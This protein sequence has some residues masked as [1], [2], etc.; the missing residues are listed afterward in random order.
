MTRQAILSIDAGTTGTRAA[1]VLADSSIHAMEYRRLGVDARGG[2]VVEQDASRI[3]DSTLD[4]CRAVIAHAADDGVQLVALALAAQR[5]TGILWDTVTGHPLA[6]AVVWQDS[7]NASL[8]GQLGSTWDP[9]LIERVGRRSGVHSVYL[10]A[11]QKLRDAPDVRR[12]HAERRLAFG[13]V[14]SWLQW[15]LVGG[16]SGE[17][18]VVSATHATAAGAYRLEDHVYELEWIEATGLPA[19]LLPEIRED[20]DDFGCTDPGLLGVALPIRAAVGDQ[21]AGVIGLGCRSRAVAACIHGTGS[22]ADLMLGDELPVNPGRYQGTQMVV[23][24]RSHGRS[25]FAAETYTPTTGAALDWACD[26]AGLFESPK[27]VSQLASTVR[28]SRGA[29]FVPALTGV[30]TP[31]MEPAARA[32]FTGLSLSTTRAEIALAVL[33]GI[34]HSVTASARANESAAGLRASEIIV[35]GGLAASDPL[36]QLQADL[37]GIPV[38][39]LRDTQSAS[40]RGAAFLAGADG[41]LWSSMDAAVATLSTDRVCEPSISADE[42]EARNDQ[43]STRVHQEL[44]HAGRDAG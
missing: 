18:A 43:W 25:T 37:H 5:A 40:I 29:A 30:R 22:F 38:R 6:P 28:S 21:P 27:A 16:R 13:T 26:T 10:W 1:Y 19:E 8:L 2:G 39:R 14:D 44:A 4:A 42:R 17:R 36:V 23:A 33:E 11:A 24:Q 9:L 34:A 7:R 12:A 32:S 35:G 15:H 3:L 31:V 41:L 20:A